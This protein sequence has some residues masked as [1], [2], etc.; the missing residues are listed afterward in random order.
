MKRILLSHMQTLNSVIH[1][2]VPWPTILITLLDGLSSVSGSFG[3]SVNA[4]ECLYANQ[5]HTD[6]YLSALIC[7]GILPFIFVT[8]L[9][10]YWFFGATN[11]SLLGC[12][13]KVLLNNSAASHA[14]AAAAETAETAETAP[15]ELTSPPSP[16]LRSSA[17]CLRST[18][19]PCRAGTTTCRTTTPPTP[20]M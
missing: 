17:A 9:S 3:D 14:L 2:Q 8:F 1:L 11:S 13:K 20:R 4:L 10:V 18:W 7:A 16:L 6:F 5:S 15:A 19:W 12:G